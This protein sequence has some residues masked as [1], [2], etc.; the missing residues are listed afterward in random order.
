MEFD[1][2]GPIPCDRIDADVYGIG[3]GGPKR[4]VHGSKSFYACGL[5][6]PSAKQF[7]FSVEPDSDMKA[8]GEARDWGCLLVH[9]NLREV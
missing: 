2:A 4:Y 1:E 7:V 9:W 3:V 6:L 8:F 5:D